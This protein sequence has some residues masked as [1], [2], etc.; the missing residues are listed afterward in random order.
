MNL[1][2]SAAHR[3]GFREKTN[4]SNHKTLLA[5]SLLVLS[6]CLANAAL[7]EPDIGWWWN[8]N[9][10]GRGFFVESH[11]GVTFIGAYLYDDDGHA[12]WLVSGG[13]NPDPYNWT[14]DLYYKINGQTLYGSYVAPGDAIVVGT[15]TAHFDNDSRGTITWPGGSVQ[16]ERQIFGAG[17]PPF[18]PWNGWWW[19]PDE[20]GSGYS[21]ELQGNNL[22]IVGFMY[23]EGGRPVWYYSAGPMTDATTYHGDVLQFANGQTIGGPYQPPSSPTKIATLDV[24]FSTAASEATFTFNEVSASEAVAHSAK[25]RRQSTKS[26]KPQL[27]K[28][29]T[30]VAPAQYKGTFTLTSTFDDTG[31][32]THFNWTFQSDSVT[33]VK[34]GGQGIIPYAPQSVTIHVTIG[35]S[36]PPCS[37][38]SGNVDLNLGADAVSLGLAPTVGLFDIK[39]IL[40]EVDFIATAH[41]KDADGNPFDAPLPT[42]WN[43]AVMS[44]TNKV[45]TLS[46]TGSSSLNGGPGFSA[47][48]YSHLLFFRFDSVP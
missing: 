45:V 47:G 32:S 7:A 44:E 38:I 13:S 31:T 35:G 37:S 10:S 43:G 23:D 46:P 30:L 3:G 27:K 29:G 26:V 15:L 9:E 19:N 21:V 40:P 6:C 17:D 33:L 22:F 2:R 12:K 39:F 28:D 8:P 36:F 20:S 11:D 41:C 18:Q 1:G 48:G 16:I 5:S 34:G 42:A 25:A 14:G 24:T 4:M